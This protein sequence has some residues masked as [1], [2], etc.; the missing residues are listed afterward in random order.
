LYAWLKF[1]G[2]FAKPS[3]QYPWRSWLDDYAYFLTEVRG[4]A[5]I[6]RAGYV[7]DVRTFMDWQFGKEPAL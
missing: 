7:S 1:H 5:S 6:T 2:R 4:L 3:Q